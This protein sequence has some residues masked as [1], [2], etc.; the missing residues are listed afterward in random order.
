MKKALLL[1]LLCP[2]FSFGQKLPDYGLDKIRVV[3]ADYTIVAEITPVDNEPKK[4]PGLYYYWYH[5]NTIHA[6]QGSFSGTLLNGVYTAYFAN[7]SL[8]EQGSFRNGLKNGLW[9]SWY[10]NG[11]LAEIIKWEIGIKSGKYELYDANGVMKESGKY[12]HNNLV[13]KDS[14]SIWKRLNFFKNKKHI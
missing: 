3:F 2:V 14:I 8:K 4:T 6:T 9:R 13:L 12:R 5:S 10:E 11:N 1:L 7:K